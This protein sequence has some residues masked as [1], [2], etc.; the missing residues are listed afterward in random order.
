MQDERFS[1]AN[2]AL[3]SRGRARKELLEEMSLEEKGR[4]K[5]SMAIYCIREGMCALCTALCKNV[6]PL[7]ADLAEGFSTA[8][9]TLHYIPYLTF[10]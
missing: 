6:V 3:I 10:S 5:A 8:L 9:Y 7:S 1:S 2:E 4:E